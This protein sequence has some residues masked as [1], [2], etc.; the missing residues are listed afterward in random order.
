MVK[1]ILLHKL[2][3]VIS[4]FAVAACF[5]AVIVR[6]RSY[7][8]AE[9]YKNA[10]QSELEA[11]RRE[12]DGLNKKLKTITGKSIQT[13]MPSTESI[14]QRTAGDDQPLDSK[15]LSKRTAMQQ[16][17]LT[18]LQRIVESTGL[19]QLATRENI[20]PEILQE[21]YEQYTERKQVASHRQNLLEQN[22]QMHSDDAENY[23]KELNTLYQRAH[24]R[25]IRDLHNED[26]K[27][28]FNLMLEKYPEANA[29][30]MVIA[31]RALFSAW[32]RNAEDVEKYYNM[33]QENPNENFLNV[34]TD[35]GIEAVPNL[36][37]YLAWQYM[38]GGRNKEAAYLIESLERN[39]P[40]SLLI[41]RRGM[42]RPRW[43]PASQVVPKL[44]Q[45]NELAREVD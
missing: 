8:A 6:Y 35:R 42:G 22:S 39:Y 1:D 36:E 29:T 43:V 45:Q 27:K 21:I 38:K 13:Q 25:T 10:Y 4:I 18:R 26:S 33:L 32:R 3:L 9:Q 17:S 19:D 30:G 28:A 14:S 44:K 15:A 41:V 31:E 2:G 12:V 37:R 23:D 20:D 40:E 11:L 24:L 16:E 7:N 5:V 34:I